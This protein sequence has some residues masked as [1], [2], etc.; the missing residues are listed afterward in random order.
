M[1]HT[2]CCGISPPPAMTP[3]LYTELFER[4]GIQSSLFPIDAARQSAP[5]GTGELLFHH[6]III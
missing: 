4:L 5:C 6:N 1:Y 2:L 3:V